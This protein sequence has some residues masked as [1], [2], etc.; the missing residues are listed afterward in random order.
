MKNLSELE[1][2]FYKCPDVH[3]AKLLV[4]ECIGMDAIIS[5][6]DLQGI[7]VDV[8]SN[9]KLL[10]GYYPKDLIGN[11]AYDYF[12]PED[13]KSTLTSHAKV[14]IRPEVD[15]VEYRLRK[16]DGQYIAVYTLSRQ[17]KSAVGVDLILALTVK[18]G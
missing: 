13:F 2:D 14:T 12:H 9:C 3:K 8:S 7:Y 6:H 18:R 11:S 1:I 5:I 17:L 16:A 10:V 15:R 4:Q